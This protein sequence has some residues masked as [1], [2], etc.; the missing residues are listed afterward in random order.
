MKFMLSMLAIA[1]AAQCQTPSLPQL[2][3]KN[4]KAESVEYKGRKAVRLVETAESQ[5]DGQLAILKGLTLK[6]GVFSL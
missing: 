4:L 1:V 5:G 6:D 2:E 3:V